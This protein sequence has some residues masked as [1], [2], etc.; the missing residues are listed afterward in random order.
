MAGIEGDGGIFKRVLAMA[1]AM[2]TMFMILI[3][4]ILMVMI[5]V[6]TT[7][8]TQPAQFSKLSKYFERGKSAMKMM[9]V[10]MVINI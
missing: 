5:E 3:L 2:V 4:T 9:I 8:T 1:M 6:M 10:T 7:R